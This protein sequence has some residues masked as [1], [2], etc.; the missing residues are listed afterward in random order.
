MY[1]WGGFAAKKSHNEIRTKNLQ[2][3]FADF[4]ADL[5]TYYTHCNGKNEGAPFKTD[6]GKTS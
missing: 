1:P 3:N 4:N 2:Y 5:T 6:A